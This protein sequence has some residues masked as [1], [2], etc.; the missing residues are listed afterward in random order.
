MPHRR[1]LIKEENDFVPVNKVFSMTPGESFNTA[2]DSMQ[3]NP[4]A[5]ADKELLKKLSAD[6][7]GRG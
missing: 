1:E 2:N 5:D 7:R 3:A 6:Q 4:P